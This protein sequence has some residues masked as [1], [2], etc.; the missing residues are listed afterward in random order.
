MEKP[1]SDFVVGWNA[2]SSWPYVSF[3]LKVVCLLGLLGLALS[4]VMLPLVGPEEFNWV[5]AH[6]E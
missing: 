5:L 4:S 6:I 3:S 1:M 2:A